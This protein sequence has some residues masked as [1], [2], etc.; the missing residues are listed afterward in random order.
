MM[1]V[2]TAS[3]RRD[4]SPQSFQ[5]RIPRMLFMVPYPRLRGG[6]LFN[7]RGS[8][9]LAVVVVIAV[10]GSHEAEF[11][12]ALQELGAGFQHLTTLR[13]VS[14]VDECGTHRGHL[15]RRHHR[16]GHDAQVLVDLGGP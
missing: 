1:A 5:N 6:G 10:R 9:E 7:L 12:G 16:I 4:T 11:A 13:M 14:H 3:M 15:V 2:P 8:V